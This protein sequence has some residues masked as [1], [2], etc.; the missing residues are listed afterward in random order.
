[1]ASSRWTASPR[2]RALRRF[3]HG[4][5]RCFLIV[6]LMAV[7][8]N[9]GCSHPD[10]ETATPPPSVVLIAFDQL[11]A[12]DVGFLRPPRDV[13]STPNLDAL[14]ARA[15]IRGRGIAASSSPPIA[16]ASL[17][18]GA[19]PWQ[20]GLLTHELGT[21][22]PSFPTLA[23]RLKNGGWS[24]RGFLPTDRRLHTYP[25]LLDGFDQLVDSDDQAQAEDTL[26]E[27]GAEP[28]FVWL[29]LRD[30]GLPWA[31]RG[32][33]PFGRLD[34]FPFV[35]PTDAMP[36]ALRRQ[37]QRARRRS[38]MDAD[39]RLGR[40][41]AALEA[42]GQRDRV[43]LAVTALHGVELGEHGQAL[44]G[45]NLERAVLEV[46]LIVDLPGAKATAPVEE[47]GR[48]NEDLK[49]L[50]VSRTHAT[51][52][53]ALGIA[54]PPALEPSILTEP[55]GDLP[56]VSSR[57]ARNG[58]NLFSAVVSATASPARQLIWT[59][60]FATPDPEYHAALRARAGDRRVRPTRSAR[61]IF[62]DLR[63]RFLRSEPF[64]GGDITMRSVIW[65]ADGRVLNRPAE[66]LEARADAARLRRAWMRFVPREQTP[67][68]ALGHPSARPASDRVETSTR[69]I[70]SVSGP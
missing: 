63:T 59:T 40:L 20:H 51:L 67:A 26:R 44:W 18:V 13:S 11:T 28:T 30:A 23:K 17:L 8:A 7:A 49:V 24:T 15:E 33:P 58:V 50:S 69:R 47:D 56:A 38:T 34:L 48:T 46:P 62:S 14:A 36:V 41:L 39:A 60:R 32:G 53:D 66:G 1:M 43:V 57:Y 22:R 27:L 54:I 4:R 64:T 68:E 3:A 2:W 19:R 25:G 37:A 52:L 65:H 31:R 10:A 12:S 9:A 70:P 61:R 21:L 6:A 29:H 5:L 35:S 42:S 16:L 55:A 45:E